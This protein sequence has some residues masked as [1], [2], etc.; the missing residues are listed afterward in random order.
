MIVGVSAADVRMH[1]GEV[2]LLEM[3]AGTNGGRIPIRRPEVGALLVDG[4]GAPH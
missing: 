2:D 4:H 1:A 3:L